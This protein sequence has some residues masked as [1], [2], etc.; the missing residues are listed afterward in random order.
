MID[1]IIV[2]LLIFSA[3]NVMGKLSK[4]FKKELVADLFRKE[5]IGVLGS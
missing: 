1:F 3:K 2:C 5:I 4:F